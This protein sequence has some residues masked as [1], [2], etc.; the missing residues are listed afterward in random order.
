MFKYKPLV[1]MVLVV[2]LLACVNS[3][4]LHPQLT[5]TQ[6]SDLGLARQ[7]DEL[8]AAPGPWPAQDW[9]TGLG[10]P[11]LDDLIHRA[12]VTNPDI[13]LAEARLREA[14]ARVQEANA[15]RGPDISTTAQ[16]AGMYLP[17]TLPPPVGVG[18]YVLEKHVDAGL[19]W[20]LDLWGG[21]RAAWQA[22]LGRVQVAS[23]E[24]QATR[25]ALSVNVTRLYAQLG[26]A[27]VTRDIAG[28]ELERAQQSQTLTRQRVEAGI[29]SNTQLRQIDAEVASDR[30]RVTAADR[31]I[32]AKR[33]ALGALIGEGPDH[34]LEMVR[35]RKI[36]PLDV[37]IPASL[38]L[39]IISHRADLTAARW[40]VEASRQGIEESRASF[41][42]NVSLGVL[43]G[44]VSVGGSNVLQLPA[45]FYQVAPSISLPIY[46]GGR[47]RA[48]LSGRNAQYDAAVAQYDATLVR[49][50]SEVADQLSALRSLG[51]QA[52]DQQQAYLAA[53]DAWQL[54]EQRYRS[55]VG[56]FL[57][58][59]VVRQQLLVAERHRADLRFEEVDSSI[60]L[61][62]ALGGGY[63]PVSDA[64]PPTATA[65]LREHP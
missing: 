46:D 53:S 20:D 61:I 5:P 14:Q 62:Q 51:S 9:W 29:D 2:P 34:S 15:A 6:P 50:I 47:R 54:A 33:L 52:D 59:L 44:F 10:D 31:D 28:I 40:S 7:L 37:A 64:A 43:A 23:A 42:P 11:Q 35:P 22:E 25:I 26:H 17:T 38:T 55:G 56:S 32:V 30:E 13:A 36:A 58:T 16:A 45:R 60:L 8:H 3:R 57:E 49:S 27:F 41:M 39:E 19:H 1:A 18:H 65:D 24:R 4:G 48:E 63:R 12:L 21:R